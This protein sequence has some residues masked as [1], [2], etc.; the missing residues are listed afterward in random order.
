MLHGH[1]DRVNCVRWIFL[2]SGHAQS[3]REKATPLEL[4]SGSVD[5]D[6]IVWR[7]STKV[8]SHADEVLCHSHT[9]LVCG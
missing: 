3:G 9:L 6:V 7:Q 1:K 8:D 2:R 5:S 4:V